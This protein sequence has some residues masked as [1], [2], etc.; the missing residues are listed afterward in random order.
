M[1]TCNIQNTRYHDKWVNDNF[2]T[3][4]T[5]DHR[6]IPLSTK[7]DKLAKV[8]MVNTVWSI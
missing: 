1:I 3:Y 2:R 7:V 4:K 8:S 6:T 5:M